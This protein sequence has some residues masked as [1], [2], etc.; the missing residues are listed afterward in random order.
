MEKL[1]KFTKSKF[2][3]MC[4]S[5][6]MARRVLSFY[7]AT[8]LSCSTRK[9]LRACKGHQTI[10]GDFHCQEK[11]WKKNTCDVCS[12]Q[13]SCFSA[14]CI[15]RRSW[16]QSIDERRYCFD[17]TPKPALEKIGNRLAYKFKTVI[18]SLCSE[19]YIV[20][21]IHFFQIGVFAI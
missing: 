9:M 7:L 10:E 8:S 4:F 3:T 17:C 6:A 18:M 14:L 21:L 20:T 2:Y 12:A 16:V 13:S 19:Y 5:D 11:T 1:C 15:K